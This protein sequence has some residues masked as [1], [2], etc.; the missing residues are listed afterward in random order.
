[1]VR[2]AEVTASPP[3]RY[4]GPFNSPLEC[5]LRMLFVLDAARG[6]P[7]DLQRL[8]SYDYL[9]VHSGDIPGGPASL[10]PAV[11]FRG[12]ELLVKRQVLEAGLNRMFSRELVQKTFG[13]DGISYRS[14]QL[15]APFLSLMRSAYAVSL[16]MRASWL[17]ERFG[18]LADA[19]LASFMT[20][21]IGRWG[22]E[23]E[24]LAAIDRLEL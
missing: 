19:E 1:M 10:H 4:P 24:H 8:I 6:R 2:A 11:P 16:R 5:G 23:F 13:T 14:T 20:A 17:S 15:T 21:R 12:N 3:P 22:T 18:R 7:A 9:L